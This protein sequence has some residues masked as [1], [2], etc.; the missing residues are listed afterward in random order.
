MKFISYTK[1]D[2]YVILIGENGEKYLLPSS[3]IIVVDDNSGL[4]TI[5]LIATR[6]NLGILV[7]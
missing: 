5:K 3:T 2:T 4:K 7:D 6:K 1:T